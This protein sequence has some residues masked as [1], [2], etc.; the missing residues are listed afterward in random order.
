MFF[1]TKIL[2]CIATADKTTKESNDKKFVPVF[3]M[4]SEDHDFP[5]VSHVSV[6]GESFDWT[7]DG[8]GGPVGRLSPASLEAMV[9]AL[10]ERL[11][12]TE[13]HTKYLDMFAY[14]YTHFSTLSQATHYILDQLFGHK[15][16]VV[17]DAD[18]VQ[19]KS[20]FASIMHADIFADVSTPAIVSQTDKLISA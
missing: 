7:M 6:Y 13:I 12:D 4:A 5:E 18:D 15:G 20:Q 9:K 14:A 1:V 17:I 2:D 16:L 8:I 11:D 19:L 3:W 10:R